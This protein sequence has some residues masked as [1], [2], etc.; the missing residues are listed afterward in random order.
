MSA[1]TRVLIRIIDVPAGYLR[2][3]RRFGDV[4]QRANKRWVCLAARDQPVNS[5]LMYTPAGP[6]PGSR[7][8]LGITRVRKCEKI[9]VPRGPFKGFVLPR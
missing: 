1:D 3:H 9:S 7:L 5:N 6:R 4:L 2:I 8:G